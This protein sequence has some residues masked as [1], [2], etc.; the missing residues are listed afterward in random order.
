MPI[1]M[2]C[3]FNYLLSGRLCDNALFVCLFA[4]ELERVK[5]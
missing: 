5:G 1:L 3:P 4:K 2:I